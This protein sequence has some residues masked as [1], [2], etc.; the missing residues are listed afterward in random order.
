MQLRDNEID[1]TKIALV[2]TLL[3]DVVHGS[4]TTARF[5]YVPRFMPGTV[6]ADKMSIKIQSECESPPLGRPLHDE[7]GQRR[8]RRSLCRCPR[9]QKTISKST[10]TFADDIPT[11]RTRIRRLV[12][13][14]DREVGLVRKYLEADVASRLVVWHVDLFLSIICLK[15]WLSEGIIVRRVGGGHRWRSR[16]R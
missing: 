13:Y 11:L 12:E 6:W 16:C 15:V 9:L 14:H 3:G 4:I 1:V 10:S 7:G 2:N 8:H 5:A